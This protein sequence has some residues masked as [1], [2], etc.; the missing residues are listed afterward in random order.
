MGELLAQVHLELVEDAQVLGPSDGGD[1][2]GVLHDRL[3]FG[4]EVLV[5]ELH[6]FLYANVRYICHVVSIPDC[7]PLYTDVCVPGV[8][9]SRA[10][11]GRYFV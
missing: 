7:G 2:I 9:F 4:S 1:V 6:Q 3:V 8:L 10:R 11:R 5:E